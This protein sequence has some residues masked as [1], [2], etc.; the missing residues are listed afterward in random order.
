M[1]LNYLA[2]FLIAFVPF[3]T[4]LVWYHPKFGLAKGRNATFSVQKR[5]SILQWIL[6]FLFS[7]TLV[8]GYINLII[9]QM[10]FYELFFTDIMKGSAEA[11][12]IV[13]EFMGK[14]GNKHRHFGHGV[15]H[16]AINALVFVLPIISFFAM[17]E[18]RGSRFVW[19]HFSYWLVTSILIGGL[20]SAFV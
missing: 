18:N 9:H 2:F 6:L 12:T 11:Q 4:G 15:F 10:G 3:M 16:G 20:I 5:F 8:Y 14:Y 19:Y 13:D 1:N 7:F 17:L